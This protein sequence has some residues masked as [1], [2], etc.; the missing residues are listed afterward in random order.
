M[1]LSRV[2]RV[3]YRLIRRRIFQR[4]YIYHFQQLHLLTELMDPDRAG[5]SRSFDG[6]HPNQL[7]RDVRII[8]STGDRSND[9][10][11]EIGEGVLVQK[12]ISRLLDMLPNLDAV[13]LGNARRVDLDLSMMR[14]LSAETRHRITSFAFIL[15]SNQTRAGLGSSRT[16][17]DVL[18]PARKLKHLSE[19]RLARTRFLPGVFSQHGSGEEGQLDAIRSME[20]YGAVF[21]DGEDLEWLTTVA[22]EPSKLKRL[23]LVSPSLVVQPRIG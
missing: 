3:W 2:S 7:V 21:D 10:C 17:K 15:G 23:V 18:I 1:D 5:R 9:T 12:D 6:V 14:Y 19:L 11:E 20:L 8:F 22:V 16:L 4:I 13:T